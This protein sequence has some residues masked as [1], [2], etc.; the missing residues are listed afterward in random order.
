MENVRE[1]NRMRM[2]PFAHVRRWIVGALLT[3]AVLAAGFVALVWFTTFHPASTE[4]VAVTCPD[5]TPTLSSGQAVKILTWNIQFMA[6]KNHV[7]FFDVLEGNGPDER[8]SAQDMELT[9]EEVARVIRAE[10]PDI[11]LL[12]EVDDGAKRTD[13]QDQLAA[14]LHRL[15]QEYPCYCSALYWKAR[16]VPHPRIRGAVGMKL[17]VLSKYRIR[18]AT[19]HQLALMPADAFRRQFMLKRA[20]LEARLPVRGGRDFVV[21]CTHL[22]AF[23]QGTD[24]MGRQVSEVKAILDGL[25]QEQLPCV[26]GG[27]FNLLPPGRAYA[28]LPARQQVYFNERT[29]IA[30]LFDAFQAVPGLEELNSPDGTRWFTHFPNDPSVKAPDRTIDY[31]FMPKTL[32]LVEHHVRQHDTLRISDHFPVVAT[33]EIGEN[34]GLRMEK[35]EA[36]SQMGM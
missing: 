34:A 23:A 32:Y 16:Y 4:Q 6:G 10:A 15:G 2:V 33:V 27:D 21:L 13:Y 35:T 8:P 17:A 9:L 22:D 5:T 11:V 20:V 30:P 18:Q 36:E 12:Q 31:L 3:C 25:A 19:R 14:L 29:E 1:T 7:F 28:S 26:I 24:T